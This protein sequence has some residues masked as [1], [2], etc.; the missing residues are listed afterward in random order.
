VVEK[1]FNLHLKIKVSLVNSA[2]GAAIV[3]TLRKN[4][5]FDKA[6][7]AFPFLHPEM[8]QKLSISPNIHASFNLIFTQLP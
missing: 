6:H 4:P 7:L 8:K 1:P 2:F 5:P 3:T